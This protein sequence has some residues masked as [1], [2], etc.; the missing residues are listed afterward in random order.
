MLGR[1]QLLERARQLA[2]SGTIAHIDQVIV[3]LK[4]EGYDWAEYYFAGQI[5][6]CNDTI[7]AIGN[8]NEASGAGVLGPRQGRSPVL[9][10]LCD[11]MLGKG[12]ADSP[13]KSI[14]APLR[15]ETACI[16]GSL[17]LL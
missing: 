17:R 16:G 1:K 7:E 14:I 10:Q 5:P 4:R 9:H 2:D 3:E 15:R 6:I 11:V 8:G 12:H 13:A